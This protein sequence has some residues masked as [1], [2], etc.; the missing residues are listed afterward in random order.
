MIQECPIVNQE[1]P[2]FLN[3][4]SPRPLDDTSKHL[5]LPSLLASV[6]LPTLL[7]YG[8]YYR[9]LFCHHP[10]LGLAWSV[11]VCGLLGWIGVLL[12]FARDAWA[13]VGLGAAGMVLIVAC[14][15]TE[16]ADQRKLEEQR[17]RQIVI[18]Q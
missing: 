15:R 14:G 13:A 17:Q 12:E 8:V 10:W 9:Q 5:L 7:A 11:I 18:E 1:H 2:S 6:F 3:N 16:A 4:I